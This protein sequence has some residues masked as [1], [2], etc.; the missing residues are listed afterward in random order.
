MKSTRMFEGLAI[1][2]LLGTN[3][4]SIPTEPGICQRWACPP[5]KIRDNSSFNY[6]FKLLTCSGLVGF[7]LERGQA[8]PPNLQ[9]F[10]ARPALCF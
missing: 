9:I 3:Y 10:S 8:N 2:S 7:D 5:L 4:A 6:Q 1:H